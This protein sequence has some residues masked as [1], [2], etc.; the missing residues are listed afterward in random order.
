MIVYAASYIF[1]NKTYYNIYMYNLLQYI[2]NVFSHFSNT[3]SLKQFDRFDFDFFI[4]K[5]TFIY[6]LTLLVY[7]LIFFRMMCYCDL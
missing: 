1:A 7:D 6:Y 3:I 5:F 4:I 2:I